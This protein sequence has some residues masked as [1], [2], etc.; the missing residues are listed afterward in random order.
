MTRETD[1]YREDGKNADTRAI[2]LRAAEDLVRA[3]GFDAVSFANLAEAAGIRKAS[4]HHHFATKGDLALALVEAYVD[5]IQIR[6]RRIADAS[7]RASDRLLGFIDLYRNAAQQGTRLCLCVAMSVTQE[8]LPRP[9]VAALAAF[10][11]D[12]AH[13]LTAALRLAIADGSVRDVTAP[14]AEAHAALAQ[15][16]GAQVMARAA[17]DIARFEAAVTTLRARMI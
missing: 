16:E 8:A 7:T 4:V 1:P 13:W 2:L 3:R 10:H 9:V 12:V 14:Q 17:G 15:V 11:R 6:L 5:T